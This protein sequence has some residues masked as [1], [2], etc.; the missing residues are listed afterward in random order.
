MDKNVF[1]DFFS[2]NSR[3]QV[4]GSGLAKGTE[5]QSANGNGK[6]FRYDFCNELGFVAYRCERPILMP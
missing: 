5:S 1:F 4:F 6:C 2:H 3:W